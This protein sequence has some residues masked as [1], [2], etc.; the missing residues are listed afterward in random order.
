MQRLRFLDSL[1]GLA[2]VYVV[3]FHTALVPAPPP[4]VPDFVRPLVLFGHTGVY[5]FFVISGFSLSLTMPRHTASKSPLASYVLSRIFR[6]APLFYFL[7]A[8][9]IWRDWAQFR[10]GQSIP[11]IIL[12]ASFLFNFVPRH[13]EGIVWASWTIGVEMVYYAIFPLVFCLSVM[14]KIVLVGALFGAFW[15]MGKISAAAPILQYS[16]VGFLPIFLLGEIAFAA[17]A[18]LKDAPLARRY[19]EALLAGGTLLLA[20]CIFVVRREDQ[21]LWRSL[22][23][24]GY[25]C[26]LVGLGLVPLK[27]IINSVTGFLGKISYSTYLCHAPIVYTLAPAYSLV[28]SLLPRDLGYLACVILTLAVVAPVA[29]LS[30]ILIE[31]PGISLGSKILN[32]RRWQA[33][34]A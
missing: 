1:R 34:P 4:V 16:C 14:R 2:A 10:T 24:I 12:N 32:R 22:V 21:I 3:L 28:S 7:L 23:S 13:Q 18:L 26:L 5:L 20:I 8:A 31:Q 25:A 15:A 11:N 29:Y 33:S 30:F 17:F 27:F 9:S 19:G 6:I